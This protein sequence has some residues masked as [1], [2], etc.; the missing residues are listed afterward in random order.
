MSFQVGG[1]LDGAMKDYMGK[2]GNRGNTKGAD[3]DFEKHLPKDVDKNSWAGS[4]Y[5]YTKGEAQNV[6]QNAAGIYDSSIAVRRKNITSAAADNQPQLS[7]RAQALLEEL[8]EKYSNM[9]F[10][11]AKTS[12]DEEASRIM[13]QGTKEYSVLIDPDTLEK[14]AADEEFKN[15]CLTSLEE[16]TAQ[17]DEL[18]ENLGED[19]GKIDS[20]GVRIGAD[21][22]LDFFA[23]LK[24]STEEQAERIEAHRKEAREEAAA[25]EKAKADKKAKKK[26]ELEEDEELRLEKMAAQR[27]SQRLQAMYKEGKMNPVHGPGKKDEP[28]E[29][30]EEA[31]ETVAGTVADTAAGAVADTTAGNS[32]IRTIHA[33]SAAELLDLIRNAAY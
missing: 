3:G 6:S 28:V 16:S 21:G 11:V 23:R 15:K 22:T 33:A 18:M 4:E 9:D 31:A 30:D 5:E 29:N 26:E 13:S 27:M 32:R 8:K 1:M 25:D 7:E 24:E 19:A 14:M 12:S 17:M 20:I 2:M 10:F